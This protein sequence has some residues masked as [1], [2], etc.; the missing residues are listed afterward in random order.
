MRQNQW[1]E[2]AGEYAIKGIRRKAKELKR[3]PEFRHLCRADIEQELYVDLISRFANYKSEKKGFRSF[4]R[5]IIN[6]KAASMV[7]AENT[8]VE[9]G[10]SSPTSMSTVVEAD[11]CR[12]YSLGDIISEEDNS[13]RLGSEN[14]SG[15]EQ[16]ELALDMKTVLD[17]LPPEQR[18]LCENLKTED[19]SE[20]AGADGVSTTTVYNKINIIRKSLEKKL[21][22]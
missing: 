12:P 3:R 4:I 13:R 7:Q 22:F 14:K 19:V 9:Q 10:M 2:E 21:T 16:V 17:S 5:M 11:G 8:R 15:L 1:F 18:A 6:N 20:I